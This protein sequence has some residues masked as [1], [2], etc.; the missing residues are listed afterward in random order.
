MFFYFLLEN[1]QNLS[2]VI[3][4]DAL[5]YKSGLQLD[6]NDSITSETNCQICPICWTQLQKKVKQKLPSRCAANKMW[7][8][9]VPTELEN[10]TIPEQQLISLYRHNQCV[11]KFESVFHSLETQQSKLKGNCISVITIMILQ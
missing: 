1:T 3:Y 4:H 9:D 7:I 11:M 8:G 10:L 5:L 6:P 2:Y